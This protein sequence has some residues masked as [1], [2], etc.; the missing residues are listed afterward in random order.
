MT[1]GPLRYYFYHYVIT[2]F[3]TKHRI[4]GLQEPENI[5]FTRSSL[6]FLQLKERTKLTIK[7]LYL[8]L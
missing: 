7:S 2:F 8:Y 4:Q 5:K 3:F 1:P 6:A